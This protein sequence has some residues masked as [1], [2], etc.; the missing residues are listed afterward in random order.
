MILFRWPLLC[1]VLVHLICVVADDSNKDA[2]T[3]RPW[4]YCQG[5]KHLVNL[6]VKLTTQQLLQMKK[7]GVPSKSALEGNHIAERICDDPSFYN[8]QPFMRWSCVKIISEHIKDFLE[9]FTGQFTANDIQNKADNFLRASDICVEHTKACRQEEFQRA[10]VPTKLRTK[11]NACR[12]IAEELDTMD[13]VLAANVTMK[14]T[15]NEN[16]CRDLGYR[17]YPYQWLEDVCEEMIEDKLD[18]I[19]GVINFQ[20]GFR[21]TGF[22]PDKSVADMMCDEFF[23]CPITKEKKEFDL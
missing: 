16:F 18:G 15:L 13:R 7:K 2:V 8:L 21:S 6:Y 17:F 14:A 11:C 12:I 22:T 4:Q 5:C 3:I 10:N 1:I 9:S 19:L 23:K 20:K